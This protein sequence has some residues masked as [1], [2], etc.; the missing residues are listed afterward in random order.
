MTFWTAVR[1][2]RGRKMATGVRLDRREHLLDQ[3]DIALR[4]GAAASAGLAG[5][6]GGEV[7]RGGRSSD[8]LGFGVAA[9]KREN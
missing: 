5:V 1:L 9:S 2:G 6:N 3:G 7:N 8:A 4:S